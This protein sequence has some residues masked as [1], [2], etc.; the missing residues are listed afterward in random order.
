V[1]LIR[2]GMHL[3]TGTQGGWGKQ[4]QCACDTTPVL[5]C[6]WPVHPPKRCIHLPSVSQL[7]LLLF[8]CCLEEGNWGHGKQ[9]GHTICS[10]LPSLFPAVNDSVFGSHEMQSC[11]WGFQWDDRAWLVS[12]PRVMRGVLVFLVYSRHLH[13]KTYIYI[14]FHMQTLL[15]G[16]VFVTQQK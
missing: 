11:T 1:V 6:W 5:R 16:E 8:S 10:C 9:P 12:C 4:K 2:E 7:P 14:I 15:C 3:R 13:H